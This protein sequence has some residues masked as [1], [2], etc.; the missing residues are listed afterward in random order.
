MVEVIVVMRC[1]L[2]QEGSYCPRRKEH[3]STWDFFSQ[4]NNTGALLFE[5]Q[6]QLNE[7]FLSISRFVSCYVKE[8]NS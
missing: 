2:V 4:K 7:I 5:E 3:A 6:D 8:I 1:S